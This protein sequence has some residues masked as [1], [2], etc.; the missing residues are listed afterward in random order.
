[1]GEPQ[2]GVNKKTKYV[3]FSKK[4]NISYPLIRTRT[5]DLKFALLLYYRRDEKL[6]NSL[7]VENYLCKEKVFR[8][9]SINVHNKTTESLFRC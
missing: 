1:M 6:F 3:R 2:N 4:K 8:K 7:F 9:R 5:F